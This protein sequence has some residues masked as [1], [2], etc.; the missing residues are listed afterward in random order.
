[1]FTY[2]QHRKS[3]EAINAT[4]KDA[5]KALVDEGVKN[6]H[7]Y[8]AADLQAAIPEDG[9]VDNIHFTDLGMLR[10]AEEIEPTVRKLM[11]MR[12]GGRIVY[13]K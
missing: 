1:M 13:H 4:L 3:V 11:N 8:D 6:I 5:F 7:L 9:R 12:K 10:M 2:V